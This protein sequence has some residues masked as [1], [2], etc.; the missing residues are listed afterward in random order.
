[1]TVGCGFRQE[2]GGAAFDL[3][4]LDAQVVRVRAAVDG[5]IKEALAGS[6]SAVCKLG[7]ILDVDAD[8]AEVIVLEGS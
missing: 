2:G 4:V 3:V 5:E 8:E 7:E 6:P 1:M